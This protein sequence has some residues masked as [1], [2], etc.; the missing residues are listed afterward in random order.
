MKMPKELRGPITIPDDGVILAP[1]FVHLICIV[2]LGRTI[3]HYLYYNPKYYSHLDP[4]KDPN[5]PSTSD[6][7]WGNTYHYVPIVSLDGYAVLLLENCTK[8]AKT[9]LSEMSDD[10]G[11]GSD[12]DI[13]K[14]NAIMAYGLD[15]VKTYLLSAE[16][17]KQYKNLCLAKERYDLLAKLQNEEIKWQEKE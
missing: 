16:G 12:I 9:A 17:I 13:S 7:I 15:D 8:E 3:D 11:Y 1:Y 5:Q 2:S 10:G 6:I 4:S 14:M